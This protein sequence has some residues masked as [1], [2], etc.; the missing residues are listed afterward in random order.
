MLHT[1]ELD[2]DQ[3]SHNV[4]PKSVKISEYCKREEAVAEPVAVG[5]KLLKSIPEPKQHG[6]SQTMSDFSKVCKQRLYDKGVPPSEVV[7]SLV[8]VSTQSVICQQ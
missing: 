4:T 6:C 7:N 1:S 8:A 3:D 5:A 2:K